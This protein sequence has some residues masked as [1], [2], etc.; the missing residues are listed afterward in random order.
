MF[1]SK[2]CFCD[3][4]EKNLAHKLSGQQKIFV[5]KNGENKDEFQDIKIIKIGLATKV[6]LVCFDKPQK[7]TKIAL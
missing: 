2:F 6:Y 3:F 4:C 1:L 5:Y 7:P